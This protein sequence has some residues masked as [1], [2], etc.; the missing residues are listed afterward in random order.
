M[1]KVTSSTLQLLGAEKALFRHIRDGE[2][3]PKHGIIF[4]HP[5]IHNAPFWQ[6]G[7][8]ARAF[9]GKIAIAAKI[10][11]NSEKFLGDDLM[12]DLERRIEEIRKKYPDP[13]MK[14]KRI[15]GFKKRG[16]DGSGHGG[17]KTRRVKRGKKK[18]KGK[19]K[20]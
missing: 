16:G 17:K 3:P 19:S 7:K 10:D 18:S 15:K 13:P 9:A 2:R 14:K 6:R 1:A 8:I 5:L 11:Q 20:R 4:Q 12:K